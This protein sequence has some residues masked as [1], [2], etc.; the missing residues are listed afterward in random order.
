MSGSEDVEQPQSIAAAFFTCQDLYRCLYLSLAGQEAQV[1]DQVN[2]ADVSDNYG[3]LNIWGS[4][5]GVLCTGSGSLDDM[6]RTD[7]KLRSIAHDLFGD[8]EDTLDRGKSS[9]L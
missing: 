6:L 7:D 5:S 8:L 3:R 2:M 1:A 4:D 9:N